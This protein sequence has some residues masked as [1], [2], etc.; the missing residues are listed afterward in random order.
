MPDQEINILAVDGDSAGEKTQS[1]LIV[2][3]GMSSLLNGVDS[4]QVHSFRFNRFPLA[5]SNLR[6]PGFRL[7][8]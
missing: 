8:A 6:K 7:P 3:D 1:Q 2:L 4:L 5:I